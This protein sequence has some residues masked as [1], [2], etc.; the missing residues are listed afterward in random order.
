MEIL[1]DKAI[2]LRVRNPKQLTTIIPNSKEISDNRVVV[3]WG[4]D[5]VHALKNLNI[6]APS[7][8]TKQYSWPGQYT[9]FDH[10][11]ETASFFTLHKKSFCFNE[12]GT[13]KTASAI[14]AADYLLSIGKIKRV[15]VICPLSI[16][17]SAWRNDL[18]SFAMH[19][20]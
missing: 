10:Q 6:D 19:C 3:K 7:P 13:G 1:Q 5:E 8:I 4:I 12:Q 2:M 17:D 15:L 18:F 9:P 20:P 11:K 16:M 14:W